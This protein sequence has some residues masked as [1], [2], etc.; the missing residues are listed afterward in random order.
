MSKYDTTF[1][2]YFENLKR[3]LRAMPLNLGGVVA[4]G[5]SGWGGPPGGFLGFLPQGRVSYDRLELALSGFMSA[6]PYNPSGYLISASLIDNLNR[7]RYRIAVLEGLIFSQGTLAIQEDDV[8]VVSGITIINFEGTV[9]VTPDGAGKVTITMSGGGGADEKAKVSSN[10]TTTNYLE[11]KIVA[12]SNVTVV[13]NNEGGDEQLQISA[14]TSG[15]AGPDEKVKVSSNDTT[16]NYLYNKI[17]TTS[18]LS[19]SQINDGGDE[20]LLLDLSNDI[21][22]VKVS[23]NDS[24]TAFIETKIIAGTNVTVTVVDEGVDER[25]QISASGGGSGATTFL[26]L[27]DT[28][29]SYAGEYGKVP[30]VNL[31]EDALEFVTVSGI[32]GGSIDV[33]DE[34]SVVV[35]NATFINFVGPGIIAVAS[36]S[37]AVVTV[38]GYSSPFVGAKVY[39]TSNTQMST[40]TGWQTVTWE[41]SDY[42]SESTMWTSGQFVYVREAGY[43]KVT[44]QI[45]LSG[46][47]PTTERIQFGLFKNG[48]ICSNIWDGYYVSASGMRTFQIPYHGSLSINDYFGC[49]ILNGQGTQPYIIGGIQNTAF[50]IYKIQGAV[51]AQTENAKVASVYLAGGNYVTAA[52]ETETA[53]PFT[54]ETYDTASYWASG[55][56][57]TKFYAPETGYYHFDAGAVWETIYYHGATPFQIKIGLRKN[58]TTMLV[59]KWEWHDVNNGGARA[60]GITTPISADLALSSGDYVE[61]VVWHS[62]GS[63][64]SNIIRPE[65]YNTFCMVHKIQ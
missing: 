11:N 62:K 60:E 49:Q 42:E 36:G 7:I 59:Q 6:S 61:V 19:K 63:S 53:I 40:S 10:D 65:N 13:V 50:S 3:S 26:G 64:A 48:V 34:G 17:T 20:S 25:L 51:A 47:L 14:T 2:G 12:G 22:R 16:E 1:F 21:Y 31:A 27:T 4:T 8:T 24:G 9:D 44:A 54:T 38:S 37:G 5:G 33:K 57:S 56:N 39:K 35:S 30:R 28:P 15:I 46:N 41:A 45:T 58:G 32:G 43:Y 23:S 29:V 55:A 52:N 18:P